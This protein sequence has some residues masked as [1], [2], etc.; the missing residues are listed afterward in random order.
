MSR[1]SRYAFFVLLLIVSS[2]F[3]R[4]SA[5]DNGR[6]VPNVDDLLKIRTIGGGQISPDGKWVAYSVNDTDF[7]QDA[8]VSHI[9]LANTTTG[10]SFQLTRGDKS[11]GN[12]Q[13]APDSQWL[14]FASTGSGTRTSSLL[15]GRR[16]ASP[17]S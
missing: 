17:C 3:G 1:R 11:A 16:A 9:W 10:T 14:V 6:R 13:W 2:I 7:K 8:F 4:V 12:A 15:F 5:N